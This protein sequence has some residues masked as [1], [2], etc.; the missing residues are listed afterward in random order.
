MTSPSSFA[1]RFSTADRPGYNARLKA[2]Q[3]NETRLKLVADFSRELAKEI[4]KPR[5]FG[6]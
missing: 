1:H 2:R 5:N 6:Q 3:A 4:A